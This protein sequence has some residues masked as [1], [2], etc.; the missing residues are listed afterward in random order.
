LVTVSFPAINAGQTTV[1]PRPAIWGSTADFVDLHTYLGW[2]LSLADYVK[3]FGV[4][5]YTQKPIILGEFGVS[6]RGYLTAAMAAQ[7][8]L[9]WQIDSCEYGF[10]GWLLWTWDTGEQTE[11]WNGMSENGEI[12]AALAPKERPDP[13]V[14]VGR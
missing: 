4:E 14:S 11:L 7:D 3:R 13:C 1:N 9:E 8:L 2:G 5:G 10:D 12:N 6:K